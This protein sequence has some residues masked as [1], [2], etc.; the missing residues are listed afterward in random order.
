MKKLI[1]SK[2]DKLFHACLFKDEELIN[3]NAQTEVK[4]IRAF[5][6]TPEGIYPTIGFSVLNLNK[7][8]KDII[9]L[10]DSF[11][12]I[13]EGV[14][15]EDLYYDSDGNKWCED[16]K[17]IDQ[18]TMLGKACEIISHTI[19]ETNGK[20]ITIIKRV[21]DKDEEV[22]KG[23][24]IMLPESKD[25]QL[26]RQEHTEEEAR[27]IENNKKRIIKDLKENI[28]IIKTGFSFLGINVSLNEEKENAL[29]F[30]DKDNNFITSIV[31]SDTDGITQ[32]EAAFNQ[33]LNTTF[34]DSFGNNIT[35]LCDGNRYI[36]LLSS[37]ESEQ[38]FGYRVEITKAP[39]D[40]NPQKILISVTDAKATYIIKS[41][42]ID[43]TDLKV[44]LNNQFGPYGNYEDGEKRRLWYRH[45]FSSTPIL[46]MTEV[47]WFE[48]GNS[49]ISTGRNININNEPVLSGLSREQ[50]Q[51]F[52]IMIASHP[53]NVELIVFTLEE[54]DKRLPGV[55]QY[56]IN[57]FWLY[58]LLT[59]PGL[60]KTDETIEKI[61]NATKHE[62]CNIRRDDVNKLKKED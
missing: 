38:G 44:E 22:V 56:V 45:G 62:K 58:S 8:K 11:S 13:D 16:I 57:N 60:S 51:V 2:V 33:R 17:T 7:Y 50:L 48:K 9:Q 39:E 6:P 4:S 35:Y 54:L 49:L 5:V 43:K 20:S 34:I 26:I 61:I 36:F 14:F 19:I 46:E 41:F 25:T 18:L 31:Y 47:E 12:K 37:A 29:D 24:T 15:W 40:R 28:N 30:Y 59:S 27:L 10:F 53:R 21:R 1:E 52:A 55:M 32:I 42:E 23:T 3:G